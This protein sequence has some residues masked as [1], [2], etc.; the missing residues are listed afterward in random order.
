M[1]NNNKRYYL[2]RV[3]KKQGYSFNARQ[4]VVF[5]PFTQE[6]YSEQV[7]RLRDEFNY[8]IQSEIV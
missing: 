5:V 3:I 4:H 8:S 7:L 6:S 1:V 2:H